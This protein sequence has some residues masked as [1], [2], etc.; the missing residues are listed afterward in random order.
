MSEGTYTPGTGRFADV[1]L[2]TLYWR[3]RLRVHGIGEFQMF[4][5][6]HHGIDFQ[7][8]Q[9]RRFTRGPLDP[10]GITHHASQHL[11]AAADP[12]HVPAAPNVSMKVDV[13]ALR[14]QESEITPR[15]FRARQDHQ[16]DI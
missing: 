12:E 11:I 1:N 13:P 16:I 8:T 9:P 10:G 6:R 5:G 3:L 4:A 7:Q 14:P 15:R 2:V